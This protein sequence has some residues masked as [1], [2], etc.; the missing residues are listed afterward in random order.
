[1]FE[2][3]RAEVSIPT[4]VTSSLL[5]PSRTP[6]GSPAPED[7]P[8]PP[9]PQNDVRGR[10][11]AQRRPSFNFLRRGKSQERTNSI[12]STSGGKLTKRQY[13]E[14][15]EQQRE[16]NTIPNQPPTIPVLERTPQLQTFGGENARDS[17]DMASSRS[18][19][20]SRPR[21][22]SGSMDTT[23]ANVPYHV[24]IPPVP[25]SQDAQDADPYA[26]TESMAHRGRMSYASSAI[27]SINSP[28]RV[29]RRK[30]P[31]PFK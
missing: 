4:M 12:R 9:I 13:K 26:R 20:F 14:M 21:L 18:G 5:P 29:R 22:P 8:L 15:L 3:S 24:P 17:Y 10:Q 31:T 1:M 23:R 6:D 30:D 11:S 16:A 19:G 28:R 7:L 2:P 27:S 25:G